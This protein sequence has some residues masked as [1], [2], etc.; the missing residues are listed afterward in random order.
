MAADTS[1]WDELLDQVLEDARASALQEW[2]ERDEV[3]IDRSE[4]ADV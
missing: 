2:R 4:P 1:Q 3:A